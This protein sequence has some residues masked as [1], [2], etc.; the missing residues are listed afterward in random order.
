MNHSLTTQVNQPTP[1]QSLL[2]NEI[3]QHR[4]LTQAPS[5]REPLH[6]SSQ[7]AD[8][9]AL[10]FTNSPRFTHNFSTVPSHASDRAVQSS[11]AASIN[12]SIQD[13]EEAS[14]NEDETRLSDE[15][16]TKVE[17]VPSAPSSTPMPSATA[18]G[19]PSLIE[20]VFAIPSIVIVGIP[21]D[22]HPSSSPAGMP[23]RIPP[24]VDTPVTVGVISTRAIT[25]PITLSIAGAGGGNGTATINGRR[26]VTI[27][28]GMT[29]VQLR[30]INQTD[31]GRAGNLKLVAK[32]G[33][34]LLSS[35]SGFSV[36]AIPQNWSISFNSLVTGTRRGIAVNNN[37]ESDSGNVADLDEAERSE[38][39]Q[40][41][42]GTGVFAGVSGNNSGYLPANNPP[43]V[44][45]HRT[46]V[47]LLTGPGSLVAEQTFT[48]N[49]RRTGA[50]DIPA[51]NSGFQITRTA[52][53]VLGVVSITT[54][55]I[56]AATTANG[57]S[58]GAGTGSVS[59]TQLV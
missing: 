29:T 7:F 30:G 52:T 16:E 53:S 57:F 4:S 33:R 46:P 14:G 40:Y 51:R 3:P 20:S 1:A 35:S 38:Q 5:I 6:P 18:S 23:N 54:A 12:T 9:E 56:G 8:A 27:S 28:N 42:V 39:V 41:G 50:V 45:R 48:F 2:K 31:V 59:R 36:S 34:T 19:L 10:T 17:A 11:L 24:R 58:S 49:D 43:R 47:A 13:S 32:Q 15:D 26:A 55:K 44:D 21:S 37:W 25:T 22:I